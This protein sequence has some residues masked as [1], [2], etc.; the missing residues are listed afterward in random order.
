MAFLELKCTECGHVFEEFVRDGKYLKCPECGG[1]TEQNY[2]GRMWV[3]SV[4]EHKCNGDCK[5]CGG[6]K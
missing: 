1:K 4:K 3:N 6:C 2:S 5:H